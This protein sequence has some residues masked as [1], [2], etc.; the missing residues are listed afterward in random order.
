MAILGMIK[1]FTPTWA[2]IAIAICGVAFAIYST[3]YMN[4]QAPFKAA[5]L[6]NARV[7]VLVVDNLEKDNAIDNKK[8]DEGNEKLKENVSCF[9]DGDIVTEL[10]HFN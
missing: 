2:Y 9:F 8:L 1:N 10:R 6:A 7:T 5:A 4:G 3:G